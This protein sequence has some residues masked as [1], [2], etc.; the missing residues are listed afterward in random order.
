MPAR[1]CSE[2]TQ[3]GWSGLPRAPGCCCA[4]TQPCARPGAPCAVLKAPNPTGRAVLGSFP[5]PYRFGLYVRRKA[6]PR[7]QRKEPRRLH[8]ERHDALTTNVL[9]CFQP[10]QP[11]EPSAELRSP[12][13]PRFEA[14]Q[15]LTASLWHFLMSSSFRASRLRAEQ[16]AAQRGAGS[17]RRDRT[18]R[19]GTGRAK[20][21]GTHLPSGASALRSLGAAC[22]LSRPGMGWGLLGG[23]A[24]SCIGAA[25]RGQPVSPGPRPRRRPSLRRPRAALGG[26][27]GAA[28]GRGSR[29]APRGR[30][31]LLRA[32]R[33]T[34]VTFRAGLAARRLPGRAEGRPPSPGPR[35]RPPSRASVPLPPRVPNPGPGPQPLPARRPRAA[36]RRHASRRHAARLLAVRRLAPPP[37]LAPIG[38]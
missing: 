9:L 31:D 17:P 33:S 10:P 14:A 32:A 21:A 37:P 3:R 13:A 1:P 30:G 36:R 5:S 7:A 26:Q 27:K 29:S 8:G 24:R 15:R 20:A 12:G 6:L 38:G 16:G 2:R 23:A 22:S 19:D 11:A 35:E 4:E 25:L 18:G 28:L 34:A